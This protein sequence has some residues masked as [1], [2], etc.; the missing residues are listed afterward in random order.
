MS[1]HSRVVTATEEDLERIYGSGR[2]MIGFPVRPTDES[3]AQYKTW[4]AEREREL[5]DEKPDTDLQQ[6]ASS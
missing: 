2:L 4:R 6:P 5:A 1:E 3:Y